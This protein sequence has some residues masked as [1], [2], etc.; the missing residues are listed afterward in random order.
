MDEIRVVAVQ[1]GSGVHDFLAAARRAQSSNPQW[2]EPAHEEIRMLLDRKRSPL[3]GELESQAFVAYQA[4]L[5]VGRIVAG[6][7]K[8]HLAKFADDFGHFGFLDAVDDA[9]VFA[10]LFDAAEQFLRTRGLR[11]AR[12]PFSL[13]INQ[14]TGLL[15]DGFD[16]PHVIGTNHSPPHYAR[17]VEALGYHKAVDTLALICRVEEAKVVERV[18]AQLRRQQPSFETYRLSYRTWNRDMRR[19][20]AVYNDA[21]SENLWATP[22]GVAE[23]QFIA[24]M[25]LPVCKPSWIRIAR[26]Q[27]EDI[28]V[29]AQIP[30]VNIALKG[31]EGRLSPLRVARLMWR[32]HG[33]GVRRTRVAMAGVAKKWRDSPIAVLAIGKL[34][35]EVIE[36]ARAAGVEEIEYSWILETNHPAINSVRRVPARH[37]RTFR[38]YE[39]PL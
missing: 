23:A 14:E 26:Y 4:G 22:I 28:A 9:R 24:R 5:P 31:L 11:G 3:V 39:K 27:G 6:V 32:L 33:R 12:G 37:S 19:I 18:A 7:N 15:V 34:Y 38:I 17:H 35:A 16:Q 10:A 29:V 2:I 20:I 21:W 13:T 30:D 1:D 36:D 25:M 8:I